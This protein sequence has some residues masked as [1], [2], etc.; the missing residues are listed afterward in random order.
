M[1]QL[2]PFRLRCGA[3][4]EDDLGRVAGLGLMWQGGRNAL[5][6]KPVEGFEKVDHKGVPLQLAGS[7][8]G[9]DGP[10]RLDLGGD[11]VEEIGRD[12]LVERHSDAASSRDPEEGGD[13]FG[14]VRPL[15]EDTLARE[16]T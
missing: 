3:G 7:S 5:S 14:R 16:Q 6:A 10:L 4:G 11:A 1:G 9:D 13:P 15:D 8:G 12:A 2:D